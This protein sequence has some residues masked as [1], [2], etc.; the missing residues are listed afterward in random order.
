[1]SKHNRP[2][3]FKLKRSSSLSSCLVGMARCAVSVTERSVRR[4]NERSGSHSFGQRL[5]SRHIHEFRSSYPKQTVPGIAKTRKDVTLRVE[6]LI[7]CSREDRHARMVRVHVA[8]AL[9]G[10]D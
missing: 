10:C 4:R 9:G 1:M 7:D 3:N 6:L 8:D 5:H 2:A